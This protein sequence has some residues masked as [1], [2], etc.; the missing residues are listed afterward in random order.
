MT[1]CFVS[2]EFIGSKRAGGIATYVYDMSKA[3]ISDGHTVF[4]IC[5]SDNVWKN[6]RLYFEGIN[7]IRLSGADYFL[8]SNRYIQY[9]GTKIRSYLYFD[10]YRKKIYKTLEKLK[11]EVE[12]DIVEFPE[13][14]NEAKFWLKNK[15]E[16]VSSIVRFHGPSGH[17][18]ELNILNTKNK[19]VQSEL[20]T[21]FL[22]DG[23]SFC[24]KSLELLI[25]DNDF[26]SNLF[27]KFSNH[28]KVIHNLIKI[29]NRKLV[30]DSNPKYIFTAGSFSKSK[31]FVD[32]IEAVRLIN[33]ENFELNLIIAGKLS[34]LGNSFLEK[35]KNDKN[36]MNWLKILGPVK[37]KDLFSYYINA[38]I[39]CFP[40]HFEPFGLTCIE[41]M[42]VGGLVLGSSS[43][44]MSE[45]ITDGED[46]FLVVPK[47]EKL[48]QNKILEI[49][50][51]D[52]RGKNVIRFS[53]KNKILNK[54]SEKQ[55]VGEMV[56]FY[57]EVIIDFKNPIN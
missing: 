20:E 47:N 41:S 29:E 27:V 6:E 32:L 24:S 26:S 17:N 37:R 12:L 35:S 52:E 40:S 53:A 23:I 36:Y 46:G 19:R 50:S 45:I 25:R 14:G 22:A 15:N 16:E 48:L 34:Q 18:R 38:E 8:H 28:R 30:K 54:F 51:L 42:S 49:L 10:S 43:G 44:G 39:C 1:I 21:A 3:L 57:N 55:V 9:I 31:G 11:N 2:R 13:Y 4:V 5:A 56:S 7:L 33:K